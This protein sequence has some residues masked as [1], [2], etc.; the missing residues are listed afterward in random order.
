MLAR[1]LAQPPDGAPQSRGVPGA[2]GRPLLAPRD[3]HVPRPRRHAVLRVPHGDSPSYPH[4][5]RDRE[6]EHAATREY[7]GPVLLPG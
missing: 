1:R 5:R 3:A 6:P 4:D 2:G 7:Q